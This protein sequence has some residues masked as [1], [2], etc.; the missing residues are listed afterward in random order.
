MSKN[1]IND[2]LTKYHVSKNISMT[3][4]RDMRWIIE[5]IELHSEFERPD[6]YII[7]QNIIYGIEH[8]QASVYKR[9]KNN[10]I[11][12]IAKGS[13][14]SR[15]KMSNDRDFDFSPSI[16]NFL[17]V[18]ERNL[19]SH[20]KS[21]SVYKRNLMEFN[22][23]SSMQYRLIIFIEDTTRLAYITS[24]KGDSEIISVLSLR[25]LAEILLSHENEVWG[26]IVSTGN[27][28]HKQLIGCTL[29]ELKTRL[30]KE[31]LVDAEKCLPLEVSRDV[32]ISKSDVSEDKNKIKIII[33]DRF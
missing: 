21:F 22:N 32:H 26:V 33:S 13:Q 3:E 10:D 1:E 7:Y 9:I 20:S 5:N 18:V 2:I 12:Q 24:S 15:Y 11:S 19:T 8:F 6:A 29:H 16:E 17:S 25:Q 4:N 14:R 27:D 30:K 31:M 23:Q 28:T